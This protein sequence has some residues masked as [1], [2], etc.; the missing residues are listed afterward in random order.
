MLGIDFFKKKN[1]PYS[2]LSPIQY[3]HGCGELKCQESGD[4]LTVDWELNVDI[5]GN[6][7]FIVSSKMSLY[8][9]FPLL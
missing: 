1:K 9:K 2:D 6:I 8:D 7:L 4:K 3:I 5:Q